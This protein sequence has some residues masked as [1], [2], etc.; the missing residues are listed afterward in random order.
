MASG[1]LTAHAALGSSIALRLVDNPG[2]APLVGD[3]RPAIFMGNG[4]GYAGLRG[5]LCQRIAQG[6]FDNWLIFGERRRAHDSYAEDEVCVWQAHGQIARADYAYSRDARDASNLAP[7][8]GPHRY[9]QD[10]LRAAAEPLQAWLAR[11]AVIY[12][13]GSYD[14]M[15]TGVDEALTELLGEEGLNA[16][17]DEGRYRRDV[18]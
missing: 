3:A 13:C 16:L 9:V 12:V 4:S 1:W 7:G 10:A 14:G 5:H 18:Y 11:G 6:Q 2:F 15:A 17:I 8:Q